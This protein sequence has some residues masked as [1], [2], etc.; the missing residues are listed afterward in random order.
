MGR[1]AADHSI[2]HPD[3]TRSQ[4]GQRE[5][6]PEFWWF[7]GDDTEAEPLVESASTVH[8]EDVQLDCLCA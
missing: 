8:L 6:H 5:T 3:R 7:F 4:S 2:P 1:L